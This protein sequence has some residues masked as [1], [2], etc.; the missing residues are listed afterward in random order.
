[1]GDAAYL[2]I[3]ALLGLLMFAALHGRR[4]VSGD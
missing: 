3:G 1:M 4:N 2:I